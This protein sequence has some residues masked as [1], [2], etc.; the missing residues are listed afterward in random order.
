VIQAALTGDSAVFDT[1]GRRLGILTTRQRG[2]LVVTIPLAHETTLFDRIGDW[3]PTLS[4]SILLLAAI[5]ISVRRARMPSDNET[6][7]TDDTRTPPKRSPT[8]QTSPTAA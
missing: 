1:R 3:M 2:T 7:P 5:A 8:D 6:G 4:F